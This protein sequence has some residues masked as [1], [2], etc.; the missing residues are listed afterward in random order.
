MTRLA[1]RSF[2]W[3]SCSL[4]LAGCATTWRSG[5]GWHW[6]DTLAIINAISKTKFPARDY[7]VALTDPALDARPAILAAIEAAHLAGGGRVVVPAGSWN[8]D[9]PIHLKSHVNLHLSEGATLTFS[10]N[11]A[12]YLPMVFT[13]WEG[14]E[15]WNY[16][17]FIFATGATNVG[18]TGKGKINGQGAANWLPW[19]REQRPDQT[20]LRDMG[21]DNVPVAQRIFGAG[22]KLRPPLVQFFN[23]DRVLIEDVQLHDSPFWCVHPVYCRDVIVRNVTVISRHINSDG[24]DPDSCQRVLI[25]NCSFDVGDDGVALKAGRD[26]DG[27]RVGKVCEDIVVRNCK[28]LGNT[29][30][31]MAI[32]SEMSG[33]VRRVFVDGWDIPTASHTLYFKANLDRGGFIEDV[34][35]RNIRAGK[36]KAL[37]KFTND[38]HSYRGGTFPTR[39]R[40]ITME[41]VTCDNALVGLHI[42]GDARAPVQD[43]IIKNVTITQA[44]RPMQVANAAYVRLNNVRINGALIANVAETPKESWMKLPN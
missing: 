1:R 26:Q 39:F 33:G 28:Y 41:N 11:H 14:V 3:S 30:G 16:S 27:W 4:P 22:K 13:R 9:G 20:R 31:G 43:I 5:G 40:R 8:I 35:I 21:R 29:G 18:L 42:S 37:I 15:C 36:V 34:H 23:C 44:N 17:P 38:Y 2:L 7:E 25:E 10:G 19:R 24:V 6:S 12:S 32:G